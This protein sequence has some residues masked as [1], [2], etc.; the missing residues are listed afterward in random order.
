VIRS[1]RYLLLGRVLLVF[2]SDERAEAEAKLET[3]V[4]PH[5]IAVL[6]WQVKRLIYRASDRR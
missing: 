5:Q 3:A 1:I 6:R 4:L 2:R